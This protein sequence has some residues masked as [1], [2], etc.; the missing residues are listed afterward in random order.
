MYKKLSIAILIAAAAIT[1]FAVYRLTKLGFDY[2]FESFF[3]RHDKDTDFFQEHRKRFGTDNDFVLIG[4]RNEKGIFQ[5]DF[6]EKVHSLVDS[7]KLIPDVK[8]VVSVLGLKETIRDP[9]MGT[10]IELPYLRYDD[11]AVYSKDS[12]RIYQSA[13]LVGNL[14]SKDGKSLCILINH[15][16]LI[17][18]EACSRITDNVNALAPV[19]GFDDY[20]TAGRCVGQ[21][22]YTNVM[23]IDLVVLMIVAFIVI[24]ALM[25]LIYRTWMGVVMPITIVALT[26]IWSMALM[27]L[28]GKKIDVLTNSIP[29][30]LVVTGLSVAIH[31][32]TKYMDQLKEGK[33]KFSALRYTVTHVG[34]ANIFTTITTIVGFASL[35]TSGVK[36]IDD[37]GIYTAAGVAFSFIIGYS[38][39]PALL[40]LLPQPRIKTV[41]NPKLTWHNILLNLFTFLINR[42]KII[43]VLGVLVIGAFIGGSFLIRENTHLLE[44]MS[45][46]D[47]MKQ[48]FLFFE[49]EFSGTRPFEMSVQVKDP[50]K[51]VLDGDVLREMDKMET[52][53]HD[54][55]GLGFIYSPVA[56]VKTANKSL[57]GGDPDYYVIPESDSRLKRIVRE[58]TALK[59]NPMIS[60]VM[61]EDLHIARVRSIFPDVGSNKANQ[62]NQGLYQ[63]MNEQGNADLFDYKLTGTAELIDKNN[64]NLATNILQGLLI[65]FVLASIIFA[66]LFRSFKMVL[67]GI[68]VNIIPL[69]FL[70]GTMGYLGVSMKLSTAI[71][72]T[73]AFG[74]AVDDTIHFLSKLK[75]EMRNEKH[76]LY[77]LKRTFLTTGKAMI[78][79]SILLCTGFLVLGLSSFQA[80]KMIGVMVSFTL[81]VA[82]MCDMIILPVLIMVFYAN[83]KK[84]E[85]PRPVLEEANINKL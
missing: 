58:I 4:I 60:S 15:T 75:M 35:A 18:D 21:S 5:Q 73:I 36:P 65:A 57:A 62:L 10:V 13:Q 6:L 22:Y 24:I 72:F 51:T 3:P 77:A 7:V 71:L 26:V 49:K 1:G 50:N 82:L 66:I 76:V 46:K 61:T 27:E 28:T 54:Q 55:Y 69:V 83:K 74:I 81:F 48:D 25:I 38:V 80:V 43:L 56:I 2:N 34:I 19:F 67:I 84:K 85:A 31:V 47:K 32:V 29:T 78:I 37:F 53:L 41:K 8:E 68:V 9:L 14:V 39:L 11:P 12:V 45:E 70:S 63:F 64:R 52:Y 17:K 23:K 42:K 33:E 40:Y 44:D 20:H 79:T 59:K 16:E 30:I